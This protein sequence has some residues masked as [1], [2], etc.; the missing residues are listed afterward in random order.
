MEDFKKAAELRDIIK[1][2]T[3]KD[4]VASLL[5]ELKARF[6]SVCVCWGGG[7]RVLVL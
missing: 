5:G 2:Q 4:P 1:A 7:G 6:L 3:L